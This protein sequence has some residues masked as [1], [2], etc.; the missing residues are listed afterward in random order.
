[1][2]LVDQKTGTRQGNA[3][4]TFYALASKQSTG[5]AAIFH[6]TVIGNNSVPAVTGFSA[7]KGYDQASGLGSVDATQLV[8]NWNSTAPSPSLT[9]TASTASLSFP[10]GQNQQLTVSVATGGGFN[11]AVSLA[12]SGMPTGI[13][14]TLSSTKTAAPGAGTVAV[15]L[16]VAKTAAYGSYT[17]TINATGGNLTSTTTVQL[18]VQSAGTFTFTPNT[19]YLSVGQT[20]SMNMQVTASAQSGFNAAVAFSATGLPTGVNAAFSPA[21]VTLTGTSVIAV[22]FSAAKSATAGVYGV[23]IAASGGGMSKTIPLN[24][25]I[26][27]PS[28][29]TLAS[30][31]ASVSFTA[32]QSASF[33]VTCGSV[34]GGFKTSL[35]LNMTSPVIS[36]VSIQMLQSYVVPGA[37]GASFNVTSTQ[38]AAPGT[39]AVT[40][41]ASS[42]TGFSQTI[43]IPLKI[44]APSTVLVEPGQSSVSVK[45]GGSAQLKLSTVSSGGYK[46]AITLLAAV[47]Q[48]E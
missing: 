11:S 12:V 41:N 19:N 38:T 47:C 32:G 23:T 29:C 2:A 35:S 5:G 21:S 6:D 28:T 1:M 33:Q 25:T 27:A 26:T 44:A 45:E 20:N 3:N 17:L 43:S 42:S 7:A 36:G 30:N 37:N 39:Y 22:T 18:T 16:S 8:N 31:P 15:A 24:L 34:E 4:T 40:I 13:T 46:S 48:L 9:L 14:A 10:P